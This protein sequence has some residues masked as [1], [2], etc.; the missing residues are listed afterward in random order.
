MTNSTTVKI[1]ELVQE[2]LEIIANDE[3]IDKLIKKIELLKNISSDLVQKL[4][5]RK[6][7]CRE[8]AQLIGGANGCFKKSK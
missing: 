3:K 7:L 4:D 1:N 5:E 8:T 2:E 6:K